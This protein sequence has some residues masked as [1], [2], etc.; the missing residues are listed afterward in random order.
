ME[1][2]M[3]NILDEV[4][5][6]D[7]TEKE[8][9]KIKNDMEADWW[10]EIH[11]EKLAEVRRL[12]EQL[13]NKIAF[14]MEKLEKVQ[15]EEN[16]IIEKRNSKLVEYFETLDENDMK[17]TKTQIKYRLP[18]GE[19]VKKFKSPEYKR[20]NEKLAEWLESNDMSEYIE[21]KKSPKWGELKK[22]TKVL[23]GQV[24]YED[25][26]EIVEG[27]EAIERGSEFKVEV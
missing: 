12:K 23:N 16:H 3:I 5:N 18:S 1:N 22:K 15:E 13:D 4:L 9:W 27:V 2:I 10:I 6:I 20:D 11:E 24:V 17:E 25:T 7:E 8:E 19:L 14:Y 26:G 21:T